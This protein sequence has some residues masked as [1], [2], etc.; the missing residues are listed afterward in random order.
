MHYKNKNYKQ[1]ICCYSRALLTLDYEF[2]KF[3]KNIINNQIEFLLNLKRSILI[4]N[5]AQCYRELKQYDKA[6]C[7]LNWIIN[8][9]K[10]EYGPK[11]SWLSLMIPHSK[12]AMLRR[13][14]ILLK[15]GNTAQS[16]SDYLLLFSDPFDVDCV[17]ENIEKLSSLRHPSPDTIIKC[18][19][20]TLKLNK[21]S[22]KGWIKLMTRNNLETLPFKQGHSMIVYKKKIYC[23]GGSHIQYGDELFHNENCGE[24]L[25]YQISIIKNK[26]GASYYYKWKKLK[27]PERLKRKIMDPEHGGILN[28]SRSTTIDKWKNN[29]IVFGGNNDPFKNVLIYNFLDKEW[30]IFDVKMINFDV[31]KSMEN[32]SSVIM[33]EFLYV[34]GG[35]DNEALFALDLN[36]KIWHKLSAKETETKENIIPPQRFD[37]IMWSDK[38][39]GKLGSLYIAFGSYFRDDIGTIADSFCRRDIWRFDIAAKKWN[40]Q[41]KNG[42]F[43]AYRAESAYTSNTRNNGVIMFGGYNPTFPSKYSGSPDF[44]GQYI[45]FA[46]CFEFSGKTENWKMIYSSNHN[47]P[48][49]RALSAMVKLKNLIV[50]YGGYHGGNINQNEMFNDLWILDLNELRTKK[51][52]VRYCGNCGKSSNDMRLYSCKCRKNR[53]CGRKCQKKHWLIHK[54]SCDYII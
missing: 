51:L 36:H 12:K 44:I 26:N 40:F 39:K 15:L 11:T 38:T 52:K 49:H 5:R 30:K 18:D 32:H 17:R 50:V 22:N 23:F 8:A 1:A 43:P 13:S 19:D 9:S 41:F 27:F 31:P 34:Y 7:D 54:K 33:N 10:I 3:V 53:Y 20:S 14:D 42:N 45:Y 35:C 28:W 21:F 24:F 16:L 6:L 37:H 47:Y 2:N 25:F 29:M 46:D 4:N 48:S